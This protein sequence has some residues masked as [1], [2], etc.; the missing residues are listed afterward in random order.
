VNTLAA[1]L[2]RDLARAPRTLLLGAGYIALY[3]AL[4]W[5][6][7]VQPVR[8]TGVTAWNPNTG[9][10]VAL[11]LIRGERWAPLGA[12]GCFLGDFLI[13][14]APAPWRSTVF[15][16]L[17]VTTV[18]TLACW[19]LRQRGFARTIE[20]PAA[21]A[22]YV[23]V[24]LVATGTAAAGYVYILVSAAQLQPGDA[25]ES[26]GRYWIG[27]FNGI[28]A[29]T[30]LMLL[31]LDG[32]S[33]REHIRRNPREFLLQCLG[34]VAGM[35]LAF[36]LAAARDVRMFYPLFLP[37]TWIAL[38]YGVAGA[39]ISVT[40]AQ[41]AMVAA[42]ELTP[43]S[44]PLFD[45]QFPLLLLGVTAL[46]LGA[47]AS[48][49]NQVVEQMREQ[50]AA[51]QGA[52][53]SAVTGQ[54]ASA[55]AHEINQPL[56]AL[57]SYLRAARMLTEAVKPADERVAAALRKADVEAIRASS[58]LRRLRESYRGE[59]VDP[60]RLD[61]GSVCERVV[62][63]L[64][65]RI[66]TSRVEVQV[67]SSPGL[68]PVVADRMQLEIVVHNL[69]SNA[70]DALSADAAAT[71]PR[72][73]EI[74][75]YAG[76]GDVRISVEDSGPGVVASVA[77]RLFQPLVTSKVSGMGLGLALSR[78]L[79]RSQGADL[80]LENGARLGG[81]RFVVRLPLQPSTQ[82]SL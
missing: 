2:R 49:R 8:H 26:I 66:R 25:L 78:S 77:A 22:W 3:L 61:V 63:A 48:Q 51:L 37:V 46:F 32:A 67:S 80:W 6:S 70:I 40:L 15:T 23:G 53:R 55:L 17:Y 10:L 35:A 79:L 4:D 75:A 33:L 73:I 60:E 30:P 45:V 44:I 7:Y 16:S 56:T 18:Y 21:A 62:D 82:I 69:L 59:G 71:N 72:R 14:D 54:L 9:L 47:L 50:D 31:P 24:T 28:I 58:V 11:L 74:S 19:L 12:I 41:A 29:V 68:H 1:S 34:M 5:A 20:T 13:D 81:A 52:L 39:M 27:E 57:L 38:R 64:R 36:A 42:L 76:D 43:G 65:D